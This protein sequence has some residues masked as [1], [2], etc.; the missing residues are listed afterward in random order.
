[1]DNL[2]QVNWHELPVPTNDG[3][4]SHLKGAEVPGVNLRSTSGGRID[5][6]TIQ[7]RVVLFIY[8]MMGRPDVALP[9]GWNQV[10]GARGCTPQSCAFRDLFKEIRSAGA[11]AVFGLSTQASDAQREAKQRLHLPYELLSDATGDFGRALL[12]PT[13]ALNGSTYYRRLTLVVL[14]GVIEHVFYPVF[15]PDQNPADVLSWL[16]LQRTAGQ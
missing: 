7:G 16:T 5:I 13:F 10:P 8:P 9:S 3:S 2:H 12:L 15:P 6:S 14:N 1:M 11:D 4:A